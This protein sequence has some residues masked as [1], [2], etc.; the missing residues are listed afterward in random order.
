MGLS[1]HRTSRAKSIEEEKDLTSVSQNFSL[2]IL[3]ICKLYIASFEADFVVCSRF[4]PGTPDERGKKIMMPMPNMAT[5]FA[6]TRN[7]SDEEEE[8]IVERP[9]GVGVAIAPPPSL[10]ESSPL[11]A[12]GDTLR[13]PAA[14]GA[15]VAAK[16]MAKY[17]FKVYITLN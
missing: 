12:S 4:E 15:S 17:G 14:S 16:I 8:E 5:S 11:P 3:Q 7:E 6:G 10:Q 9:R 13:S 2:L 1:K